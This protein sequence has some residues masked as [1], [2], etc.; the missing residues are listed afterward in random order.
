MPDEEGKEQLFIVRVVS[1]DQTGRRSVSSKLHNDA[2]PSTEILK[3]KGLIHT[4]N[5]FFEKG[6]AK[7]FVDVLGEIHPAN[8]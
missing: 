1:Q 2:R 7:V 8:D 3:T 5:S 4:I 6:I